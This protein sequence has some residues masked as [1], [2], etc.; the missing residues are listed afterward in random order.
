[1]REEWC[2]RVIIVTA[3]SGAGKTTIVR[4]LLKTFEDLDFSVSATTRSKRER[5]VEGK[6]Y[7]FLSADEFKKHI[8]SNAFV[9]WEEVYQDQFYGTLTT[10]VDRIFG[11]KKH[12]VFDI[13]VQGAFSLKEAFPDNSL[14]IFIIPPSIEVL[15]KRLNARKTETKKS[16]KKR[17]GKATKELEFAD[18]FDYKLLNDDLDT[19]LKE[20]ESVVDRYIHGNTYISE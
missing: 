20:A 17:F 14:A 6:D 2:G 1:M 9:E 8:I 18:C 11:L 12:I 4:H 5:E 3:P 7:Y 10:E 13:D 15:L 19:A 16:L